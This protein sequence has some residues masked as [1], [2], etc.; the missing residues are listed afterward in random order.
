MIFC[1]HVCQ[2]FAQMGFVYILDGRKG[3][4]NI[5]SKKWSFKTE[6]ANQ[7]FGY[8][9]TNIALKCGLNK[10]SFHRKENL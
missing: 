8:L 5:I 10:L 2:N 3:N 1:I 7:L 4:Q 6:L 9:L